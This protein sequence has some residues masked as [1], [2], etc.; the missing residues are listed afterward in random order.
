M[1]GVGIFFKEWLFVK[2]FKSFWIW[3]LVLKF[4]IGN[5]FIVWVFLVVRCKVFFK[6]KFIWFLWEVKKFFA[7]WIFWGCN[8]IYLLLIFIKGL[9]LEINFL[10]LVLVN[11]WFLIDNFYWK[12]RRFFNLS[13]LVFFIFGV[14]VWI[15]RFKWE[16]YFFWLVKL[17]GKIIFSLLLVN[18]WL[19]FL[20]KL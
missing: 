11:L 7:V 19:L 15:F 4:I 18:C 16:V 13:F 6:D 14:V 1:R 5:F 3:F 10:N 20:I 17:G 2:V 9:F 12:F 8:F